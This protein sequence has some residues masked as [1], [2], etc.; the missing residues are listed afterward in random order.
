MIRLTFVTLIVLQLFLSSAVF[1]GEAGPYLGLNAGA[2]L[3]ARDTENDNPSGSF[4]LG[5]QPGYQG[6]MTLGYRLAPGSTLG[7]GRVELEVGYR[8]NKIDKIA[9]SDGESSAAGKAT[10]WDIMLNTFGEYS[11]GTRWTP[12][13]GV[14]IGA[15]IVSLKGVEV[16]GL[17]VVDDDDLVFAYQLGVGVGYSLSKAVELDL[18]YR[19]FGTTNPGL[20]DANGA[21]FDSEYLAH[22]FQLGIRVIY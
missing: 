7:K 22:N 15:A 3:M 12:Y 17:P 4:N 10:V 18:G 13:A 6:S 5:F 16:A 21:S 20:K 2:N 1:A 14:G 11:N 9:F 8:Q 19:F